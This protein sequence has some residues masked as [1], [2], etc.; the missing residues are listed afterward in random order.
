MSMLFDP[1]FRTFRCNSTLLLL[2]TLTLGCTHQTPSI[3]HIHVGH[4]VTGA[5]DTPGHV[6]YFTLAETQ[7]RRAWRIA[8]ALD[9][10]SNQSLAHIKRSVSDINAIT[11]TRGSYPLARSIR[12]AADHIEFAAKSD[13]ASENIKAGYREFQQTILPVLYRSS[14]IAS[15]HAQMR[16]ATTVEEA[17][18]LAGEI[19]ALVRANLYGYDADGNGAVGNS[20][21]E[22]GVVQ[23]TQALQALIAGESPPYTTVDK[24][25]LFNLIRLPSGEWM[26]RRSSSSAARGY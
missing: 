12:E 10:P 22:L 14:L 4:A 23:I 3:A 19:S 8:Q 21:G 25:Y 1:S 6:G 2:C 5:H 7:A 13:D 15:F 24:W 20:T 16:D 18:F 9:A 17:Q 11:N 26:F